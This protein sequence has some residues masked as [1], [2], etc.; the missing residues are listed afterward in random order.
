MVLARR[1][2]Q[3]VFPH[4]AVAGG[5]KGM[6]WLAGSRCRCRCQYPTRFSFFSWARRSRGRHTGTSARGAWIAASQGT[7]HGFFASA[8]AG[9]LR[10]SCLRC[11][12]RNHK[13]ECSNLL[14]VLQPSMPGLPWSDRG[15]RPP[16]P[17]T[18]QF[19]SGPVKSPPAPSESL[20]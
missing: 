5:A 16:N 9:V 7:H 11:Q 13:S 3:T 12:W 19:R 10:E 20:Q 17:H 4:L 14:K 15:G 6:G 8:L 18:G 2:Q 1:R